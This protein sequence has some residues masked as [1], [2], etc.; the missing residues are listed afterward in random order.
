[1]K[2]RFLYL[3]R[4]LCAIIFLCITSIFIISTAPIW[5]IIGVIFDFRA[6]MCMIR[7]ISWIMYGEYNFDN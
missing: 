1:M 2:D 5:I 3:I 6:D 4:S 7:T